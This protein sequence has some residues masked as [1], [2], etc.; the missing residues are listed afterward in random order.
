MDGSHGRTPDSKSAARSSGHVLSDLPVGFAG[1]FAGSAVPLVTSS[2]GSQ[3]EGLAE[4]T[5]ELG[6]AD[7]NHA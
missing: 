4:D 5:E 7:V 2:W 6:E 3:V 1:L